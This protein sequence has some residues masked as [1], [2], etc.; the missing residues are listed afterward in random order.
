MKS[1]YL[2]RHSLCVFRGFA[3]P[4]RLSCRRPRRLR[5]K[6]GYS[7][8]PYNRARHAKALRAGC[9][10]IG[11]MQSSHTMYRQFRAIRLGLSLYI[12]KTLSLL[13]YSIILL[14]LEIYASVLSQF[15]LPNPQKICINIRKIFRKNS[16]KEWAR[17]NDGPI[18]ITYSVQIPPDLSFLPLACAIGSEPLGPSAPASM[19]ATAPE[20]GRSP[21]EVR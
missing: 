21:P 20:S 19:P 4:P 7:E 16:R 11:S 2:L 5:G 3:G 13:A 12:Q 6:I 14:Y 1:I 8:N 17:H 10:T 9:P 18:A 15:T